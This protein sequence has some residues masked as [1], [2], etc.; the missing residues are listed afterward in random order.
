[1][2]FLRR[3]ILSRWPPEVEIFPEQSWAEQMVDSNGW[4]LFDLQHQSFHSRWIGWEGSTGPWRMKCRVDFMFFM[5]LGFF[6]FLFIHHCPQA[7]IFYKLH[8]K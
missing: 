6:L 3:E 5:Y 7:D 2:S 4:E 1:M 8:Q